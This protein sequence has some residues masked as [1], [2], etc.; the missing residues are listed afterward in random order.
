MTAASVPYNAASTVLFT[1][2]TFLLFLPIVCAAYWLIPRQRGR[3]ALLV[4]AS[5]Y[6]QPIGTF[7]GTVKAAPDAPP[8]RVE[9]LV[10]VTEDHRS[11]W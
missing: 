4:A 7:S 5:Y 2:L 10:G 8:R 9:Q 3:N 1:T 6:I 11:R